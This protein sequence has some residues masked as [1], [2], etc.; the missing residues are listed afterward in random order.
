LLEF[1]GVGD[2]LLKRV[3]RVGGMILL[4]KTGNAW[5]K[6]CHHF[7]YSTQAVWPFI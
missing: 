7:I 5:W 1:Y 6:L 3:Y 4:R 2:R